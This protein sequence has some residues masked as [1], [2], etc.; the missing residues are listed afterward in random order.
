MAGSRNGEEV[1][2]T[3]DTD[4]NTR[5][6]G[7]VAK[8][9]H[10]LGWLADWDECKRRGRPHDWAFMERDYDYDL[11]DFD[12]SFDSYYNRTC[13][14]CGRAESVA[15]SAAENRYYW[16]RYWREMADLISD[17]INEHGESWDRYNWGEGQELSDQS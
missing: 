13:W 1:T 15:W 17:E 14:G 10:V 5:D 8:A 11:D 7:T 4:S 6:E 12:D 16:V 2:L 9:M 3:E